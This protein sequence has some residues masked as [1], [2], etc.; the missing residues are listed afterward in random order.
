MKKL[1]AKFKGL[2]PNIQL[3]ITFCYNFLFWVAFNFLWYKIWPADEPMSWR[4]I[5]FKASF[6]GIFLTLT[7]NW[8]LVK[9]C[10]TKH[11]Q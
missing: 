8:K 10:F 6:M 7:F 3:I 11:E 1:L 2:N 9:Q 4:G 5:I